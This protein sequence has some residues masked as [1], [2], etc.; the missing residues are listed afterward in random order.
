VLELCQQTVLEQS[1]RQG[2]IPRKTSNNQS[3]GID[4]QAKAARNSEDLGI[5]SNHIPMGVSYTPKA[6]SRNGKLPKCRGCGA[7]LYRDQPRIRHKFTKKQLEYPEVF[8]Y[9]LQFHNS[10]NIQFVTY[11]F[12]YLPFR[13]NRTNPRIL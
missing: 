6:S 3:S 9:H 5:T 2:T 4:T 8:Q 1:P 7:E 11:H 13:L 12:Y 10:L